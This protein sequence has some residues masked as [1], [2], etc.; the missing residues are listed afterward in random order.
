MADNSI[1]K[2]SGVN[3]LV[4]FQK[5]NTFNIEYYF[6]DGGAVTR[7]YESL[8][9]YRYIGG[10][11]DCSTPNKDEAQLIKTIGKSILIPQSLM[12]AGT[13]FS[14]ADDLS[15]YNNELSVAL[16]L[17][18]N[19]QDVNNDK[20]LL[21]DIMWSRR[22]VHY[23]IDTFKDPGFKTDTFKKSSHIINAHAGSTA[24]RIESFA[25]RT[26]VFND[27]FHQEGDLMWTTK[28]QLPYNDTIT[29]QGG[30]HTKYLTDQTGY[31]QRYLR[32]PVHGGYLYVDNMVYELGTGTQLG[33]QNY[34]NNTHP[35]YGNPLAYIGN[36]AFIN[37]GD[38]S[39]PAQGRPGYSVYH[40]GEYAYSWHGGTI[41]VESGSKLSRF[42]SAAT[43]YSFNTI[44]VLGDYDSINAHA[45][46]TRTGS[47]AVSPLVTLVA[48]F[49][50]STYGLAAAQ[51][52]SMWCIQAPKTADNAVTRLDVEGKSRITLDPLV[53][54]NA[55]CVTVDDQYQPNI[56]HND[57]N[58]NV[59]IG[60]EESSQKTLRLQPFDITTDTLSASHVDI[61]W[62]Y[63]AELGESGPEEVRGLSVDSE[64]N[65]W[66]EWNNG[67]V[68]KYYQ[69]ENNDIFPFGGYARYESVPL[70][71]A[72]SSNTN[73]TSIEW[74][75]TRNGH[76][77]TLKTYSPVNDVKGNS[78]T[79]IAGYIDAT[80]DERYAVGL[81]NTINMVFTFPDMPQVSRD[82]GINWRIDGTAQ[83]IFD[84]LV[85]NQNSVLWRDYYIQKYRQAGRWG[86]Y[87]DWRYNVPININ[88][89]YYSALYDRSYDTGDS[90]GDVR[91]VD[92]WVDDGVIVGNVEGGYQPV[93]AYIYDNVEGAFP[94]E[95]LFEE[96][97]APETRKYGKRM[98]GTDSAN[99]NIQTNR[100]SKLNNAI[101]QW[102]ALYTNRATAYI[103][104]GTLAAGVSSEA[105]RHALIDENIRGCRIYPN[106]CIPDPDPEI[107]QKSDESYRAVM[108]ARRSSIND[109]Y[110]SN[111]AKDTRKIAEQALEFTGTSDI[112]PATTAPSFTISV[113]PAYESVLSE[114]LD[115]YPWDEQ[116]IESTPGPTPST[117]AVSI[118][119]FDN[120]YAP[121]AIET[122]P[123]SFILNTAT[124]Q[125]CNFE[126]TNTG[127]QNVL[128]YTGNVNTVVNYDGDYQNS[129]VYP[130]SFVDPSHDK[131][132]F[133][134]SRMVSGNFTV[135]VSATMGLDAYT[136]TI[137]RIDGIENNIYTIERWPT[138]RFFIQLDE[139][140][141]LRYNWLPPT[142]C[143]LSWF[144]EDVFTRD[145]Y[146][147][148][149]YTTPFN[150]AVANN[151]TAIAVDPVSARF[152]DSSIARSYPLSSW[153]VSVSTTNI[154]SEEIQGW[155]P[156]VDTKWK[157]V[158][159]FN[160][161]DLG[162]TP[163]L[164]ADTINSIGGDSVM[165]DRIFRYGEYQVTLD[166]EA[167][168]FGTASFDAS[169]NRQ[170]WTQN[171]DVAALQPVANFWAISAMT[172]DPADLDAP[173]E[174][175]HLP[176]GFNNFVSGYAPNL[177]VWFMDSSESHTLP[178]NEYE[179]DYGD[180][181]SVTPVE[182]VYP[183]VT[184]GSF[185][186]GC[187]TA[188]AFS[189]PAITH[190]DF[191]GMQVVKH[192]YSTPGVYKVSM[193]A[194]QWETE[195]N[196]V[197]SR[198]P[199]SA[200]FY[201]LVEELQPTAGFVGSKDTAVWTTNP[202]TEDSPSTVYT[203]ASSTILGSFN[204]WR[205]SYDWG[206]GTSIE[207][208]SRYPNSFLT[209]QGT[210]V[211]A[212]SALGLWVD[213]LSADPFD[214]R[215]VV[216]PHTYVNTTPDPVTYTI[217]MT[218]YAETSNAQST[219]NTWEVT[220]DPKVVSIVDTRHLIT[221]RFVNNQH[222]VIYALD[223]Q[224]INA[225][226]H[227][228]LSGGNDV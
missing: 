43:N 95:P 39:T 223:G 12:P 201:V 14:Y 68:G 72:N 52:A 20:E 77:D 57:N 228:V 48:G 121:Y 178:I 180:P 135:T 205:V 8:A 13:K 219:A 56:Y 59:I 96:V 98:Y 60:F 9:I 143:A 44:Y 150:D 35:F 184:S 49:S 122:D 186:I 106:F 204:M 33:L 29:P 214:P 105:H 16:R 10:L 89:R 26:M 64:G 47:T 62:P 125:I 193:D 5:I 74:F 6:E 217:G 165:L 25:P 75:L 195:T 136:C 164:D 189:S 117:S 1:I 139:D 42:T 161:E 83:H 198:E 118:T 113:D 137:P 227:V 111:F 58:Y 175:A 70:S 84:V 191:P 114:N 149:G 65:I 4:D 218:A 127:I 126:T 69:C 210:A 88:W 134:D 163:T 102:D 63:I 101:I 170:I 144:P 40:A 67:Y 115:I 213:T 15:Q 99:S 22:R 187:W 160:P 179:W 85:N 30:V 192:T 220:V 206:D 190:I 155:D 202:V 80:N 172:I 91:A 53:S 212:A 151:N 55:T 37:Y 78:L 177:T 23:F 17:Q 131:N 50:G 11:N 34:L 108:M 157:Y 112:H 87:H 197:C 182:S 27:V 81:D 138:A 107:I 147:E 94:F 46:F 183:T 148:F 31:S 156:I 76:T 123:G 110:P 51:D 32:G 86:G 130:Y 2:I 169:A 188:S 185:D 207:S 166:V 24:S 38:F 79:D 45:L 209:D 90:V 222:D 73:T 226:Y 129:V 224:E 97:A 41:P 215:Q 36:Q 124:W 199:G 82:F 120:L 176:D 104:D 196:S 119:G 140:D 146:P 116:S 133:E 92:Q 171:L 225:T 194:K 132:Y 142:P 109:A 152:I 103:V 61:I 19:I 200:G 3:S 158:T 153:A 154:W 173:L 159:A 100:S 216:I 174:D 18:Y 54:P 93:Y 21:H 145:E 162:Y 181:F 211:S 208:Y 128:S 7:D 221:S 167:E 168:N 28:P 203:L 66:T 71:G 141:S